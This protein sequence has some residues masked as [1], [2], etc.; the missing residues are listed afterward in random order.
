MLHKVADRARQ[1]PAS[2]PSAC[3]ALPAA[4][5]I[6]PSDLNADA[7]SKLRKSVRGVARTSS[8]V[9]AETTD[10]RHLRRCGTTMSCLVFG[11]CRRAAPATHVGTLVVASNGNTLFWIKPGTWTCRQIPAPCWKLWE[12]CVASTLVIPANMLCPRWFACPGNQT[13]SSLSKTD[14]GSPGISPRV[15]CTC[16]VEEHAVHARRA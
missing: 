7:Q 10:F 2:L 11:Y 6:P 15:S 5:C 9:F 13:W 4:S 8:S 1:A 3:T 12:M 16:S 14:R